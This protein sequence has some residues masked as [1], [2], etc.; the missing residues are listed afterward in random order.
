MIAPLDWGLGHA[1]RCIP[2]ARYL[3]NRRA[4]VIIAADNRPLALLKSELKDHDVEYVPFPGYDI[5]YPSKGSLALKMLRS[6]PR[7]LRG[8]RTEHEYLQGLIK[9]HDIH[10]VISDNR[11]G[12]WTEQVPCVF[13]T[14]QLMIKAP[15]GEKLLYRLNMQYIGK[16]DECWIPDVKGE[17]NLSGD[18]SHK[19]PLPANAHYIGPLT[20]LEDHASAARHDSD[21]DLVAIIS[22]PEPQRTLFEQAVTKQANNAS[23]KTLIIGGT[24]EM[25]RHENVNGS[26]TVVPHLAANELYN[27]I[28]SAPLILSRPGYSTIMDLAATGKQAIFIPTPGQTEQEYLGE[29]LMK[30]RIAYC[31]EQKEFSLPETMNES[32]KYSGFKKMINTGL[33]KKRIDAF[34]ERL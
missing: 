27:V 17:N 33:Y 16:Y 1:A 28:A 32:K 11:F 25:Q 5:A 24:P 22:G 14:H 15:F 9:K 23:I 29:L 21:Y 3:L 20:R 30:K 7:I 8:I 10:A 34:L 12:L 4:K 31:V 6:A 2:I 13:I 26:V 19:Y 18:L